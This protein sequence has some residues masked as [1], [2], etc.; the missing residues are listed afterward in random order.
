MALRCPD[1]QGKGM[2][3]HSQA[4]PGDG[5]D[6]QSKVAQRQS[7]GKAKPS[8]AKAMQSEVSQIDAKAK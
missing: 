7:N 4:E 6:K 2:A 5:M 8:K 1:Q 3:Q